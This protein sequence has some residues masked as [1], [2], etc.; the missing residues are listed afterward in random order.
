[1]QK[2]AI[3][4]YP[5]SAGSGSGQVMGYSIRNER[6]R[7]TFWRERKGSQIVA[8][9]LY[10]EQNDPHETVNLAEK[11]EHQELLAALQKHLPP[12]GSD[13]PPAKKGPTPRAV[14]QTAAPADETRDARFT[15]LY[16]G[17]RS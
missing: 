13:T 2:V 3:S 4:Q 14:T 16:P 15:R 9:E 11:P 5:R 8:T 12:V 7:A 10:D 6:F 1:M 17:N